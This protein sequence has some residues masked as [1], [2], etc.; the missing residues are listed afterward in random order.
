VEAL[1]FQTR[2]LAK[3]EAELAVLRQK[4]ADVDTMVQ[5][6]PTLKS[7]HAASLE[8]SYSLVCTPLH[9]QKKTHVV[10]ATATAGGRET[11]RR[12]SSAASAV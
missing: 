11:G 9:E 7:E 8:T 6:Y 12:V 3:T 4:M 10:L 1:R 5:E 2:T